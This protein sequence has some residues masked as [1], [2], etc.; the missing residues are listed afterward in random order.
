MKKQNTLGVLQGGEEI[1]TGGWRGG[2]EIPTGGWRGGEEIPTGGW[3][4]A[5]TPT[6]DSYRTKD[7]LGYFSFSFFEQDGFVDIDVIYAPAELNLKD[8]PNKCSPSARGGF[9][10]VSEQQARDEFT[11]KL[12]AAEWSESLWSQ[13]LN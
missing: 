8:Q 11:A 5:S 12:I 10:I 13:H 2:E 1:P 9:T 4:E 7:G 6:T 3:R